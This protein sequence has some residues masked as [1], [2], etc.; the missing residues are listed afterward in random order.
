MSVAVGRGNNK[1]SRDD[2]GLDGIPA[3]DLLDWLDGS[4]HKGSSIEGGSTFEFLDD[5]ARQSNPDG[6]CDG[7]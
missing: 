3:D 2:D 4:M 6:A 7:G 1:R 5:L